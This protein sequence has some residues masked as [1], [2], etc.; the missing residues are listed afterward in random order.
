MSGTESEILGNIPD[1]EDTGT[2]SGG[3]EPDATDLHGALAGEPG[4]AG[5]IGHGYQQ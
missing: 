2:D 4:R 1:L 3:A 5:D